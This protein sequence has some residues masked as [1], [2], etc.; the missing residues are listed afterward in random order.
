M[1]YPIE[2]RALGGVKPH[3]KPCGS[4]RSR[5]MLRSPT[6]PDNASGAPRGASASSRAVASL[7]PILVLSFLASISTG[8]V[9]NGVFFIAKE[10]YDF[11]RLPS[12]WLGLLVGGVYIP[13]ALLIGPALRT[14][15]RRHTFITSRRVLVALMVV[16]A[17][18]CALPSLMAHELAIW[19][20]VILYIP[21]MGALWPIAEAYLSGGRRGDDLR[22]ATSSFNLVWAIAVAAAAWGM[23]PLLQIGKPLYILLGLGVIH[24]ICIAPVLRLPNE[25]RKHVD[26]SHEPHPAS[27]AGL[28]L[29]FR[30]LL[31][32]SYILLATLNPIMPW[33]LDLLGMDIGW[34]TPLVSTWMVSRVG[35]FWLLGRW[36][37]WHGRWRTPLWSGGLLLGGFL[38]VLLAT[39]VPGVI[40]ALALFGV[41]VGTIYAA[42]LYYAMEVGSAEV[43]AAG[44]H[45]AVIGTGYT[46]GPMLV[47]AALMFT[48]HQSE[49]SES[50]PMTLSGLT[51]GASAIVIFFAVR[52]GRRAM[53]KARGDR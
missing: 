17:M 30:W 38:G 19:L 42:G 36:N 12:A 23:A 9:N 49:V 20:F 45:E 40:V 21:L 37:G 44:K 48:R 3:C 11:G 41:G 39:S 29:C 2:L 28:L 31:V 8:A 18:L 33:R 24:L 46:I 25:P 5:L 10:Q 51:L 50:F 1:L 26:E 34:Q 4:V 32:L 13:A 6:T 7:A 35:M 15:I 14:L 16:M 53:K 47:I 27:F 52:S 22:R 43:E